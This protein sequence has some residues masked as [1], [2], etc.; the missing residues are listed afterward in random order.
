VIFGRLVP[1]PDGSCDLRLSLYR[2][3]LHRSGEDP[4]AEIFFNAW[5][6]GVID[7]LAAG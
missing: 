1:R 5:L 7:E 4:A 3:G 6:A 2:Q